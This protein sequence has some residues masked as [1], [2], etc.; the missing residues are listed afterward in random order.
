MEMKEIFCF[1]TSAVSLIA[2]FKYLLDSQRPK[3]RGA[4][5]FI[6]NI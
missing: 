6:Y 3:S 2:L 1:Q 4:L 5:M